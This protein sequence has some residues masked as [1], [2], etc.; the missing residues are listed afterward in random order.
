MHGLH[1]TADLSGCRHDTAALTDPH[2]LRALC[3]AAV[4][5]AGLTAVGERFHRFPDELGEPRGV[6]GVLLLAESHVA[7]HT[8]PE[9]DAV[10]LDIYVCHLRADNT[11]RAHAVLDALLAAFAPRS[12]VRHAIE[13]G[14]AG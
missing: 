12:V 9:L 8:W 6:T 10:T 2:A 3:G 5:A 11:A 14:A 13:R 4:S 1:L 7:V